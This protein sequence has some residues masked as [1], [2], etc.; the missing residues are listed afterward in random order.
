MLGLVITLAAAATAPLPPASLTCGDAPS[1]ELAEG[2]VH[3]Q[4]ATPSV[5]DCRNEVVPRVLSTLVGECDGTPRDASYR[6][7]RSADSE[8][9][10]QA[11]SAA[12]RDRRAGTATYRGVPPR[13]PV[14]QLLD[15]QALALVARPR[16]DPAGRVGGAA[17]STRRDRK[18]PRG[19]SA[20]AGPAAPRRPGARAR[21]DAD[22]RS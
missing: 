6:V 15:A 12:P 11:V 5:I 19:A 14:P 22:H 3:E 10:R 7:S 17:R 16:G 9:I 8:G 2:L 1:C 4:Y 20:R 13:P 18:L 21:R